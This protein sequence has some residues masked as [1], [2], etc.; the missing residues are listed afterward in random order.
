V[1]RLIVNADDFGLTSGVNR[2]IVEAHQSGIVTST[3]AMA[4]GSAFPEAATLAASAPT[5]GVGCH[6]T[7]VD[8]TPASPAQELNSLVDKSTGRFR[9]SLARLALNA[10][11]RRLNPNEIVRE[12]SGQIRRLQA[13]GIAITHVDTHKHTH[14]FPAILEPVLE[15]ARECGIRA[16]R[17][18]VEPR[19]LH[20]LS[21]TGRWKRRLQLRTL[22][23]IAGDFRDRMKD[24]GLETTDGTLGILATGNL[25]LDLFQRILEQVPDGTWEF[26]CHPGYDDADLQRSGTRLLR[27][28][29][30]ELKILTSEQARRAIADSGFRLISFRELGQ[31]SHPT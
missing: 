2:A 25:T 30:D 18:P 6:I 24:A 27:S 28:R 23:A 9:D 12:T 4:T 21:A 17:N 11:A 13:A 5:L 1:R 15:A 10:G 7:L 22:T 3:T 29:E 16:I 31:C 14:L 19:L 20:N 8:G 26:V